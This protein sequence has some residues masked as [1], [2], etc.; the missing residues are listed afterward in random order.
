MIFIFFKMK[1]FLVFNSYF[2]NCMLKILNMDYIEEYI[3]IKAL[4]MGVF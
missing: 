3:Y 1:K 2:S 4:M